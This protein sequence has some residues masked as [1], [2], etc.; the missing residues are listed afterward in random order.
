MNYVMNVWTA[1]VSPVVGLFANRTPVA[2]KPRAKRAEQPTA[3]R[4]YSNCIEKKLHAAYVSAGKNGLTDFEACRH[5]DLKIVAKRTCSLMRDL[6]IIVPTGRRRAGKRGRTRMVCALSEFFP[7]TPPRELQ[8]EFT[9]S[10]EKT[11]RRCGE[12]K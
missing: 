4:V 1:V 12:I 11:T 6:G 10:S 3:G 7:P 8:T 2:K 5:A 9:L